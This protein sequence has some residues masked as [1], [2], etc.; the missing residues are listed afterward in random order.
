MNHKKAPKGSSHKISNGSPRKPGLEKLAHGAKVI[1]SFNHERIDGLK[2]H[3]GK[4]GV[5][6]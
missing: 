2:E 1:P 5:K 3:S 4:G 6:K